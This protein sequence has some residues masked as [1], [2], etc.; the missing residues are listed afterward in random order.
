MTKSHG[1]FPALPNCTL[2][3]HTAE[4]NTT[5]L[6]VPWYRSDSWVLPV[7]YIWQEHLFCP[8][9]C[10]ASLQHIGSADLRYSMLDIMHYGMQAHSVAG[11]E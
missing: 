4:A 11:L 2:K 7:I 6:S 10:I 8:A 3:E 9:Y 5:H 1:V